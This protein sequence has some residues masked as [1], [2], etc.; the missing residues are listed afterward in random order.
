M[1]AGAMLLPF[2]A[3][4]QST[5]QN[6]TVD[7][8]TIGAGVTVNPFS[9]NSGTVI[10]GG[11]KPF[12]AA[13]RTQDPAT[14]RE[15]SAEDRKLMW[16]QLPDE[17]KQRILAKR[18]ELAAEKARQNKWKNLSGQPKTGAA[19]A[20]A[21]ASGK[22]GAWVNDPNLTPDQKAA[23]QRGANAWGSMSPEEKKAFVAKHQSQIQAAQ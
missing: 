16:D 18:Q 19:K 12:G 10:G 2:A 20:T 8:G 23:I 6:T 17:Q 13:R 15:M 7:T 4:A 5:T 11:T 22:Q 21:G 9:T 14:V 1:I 3:Q